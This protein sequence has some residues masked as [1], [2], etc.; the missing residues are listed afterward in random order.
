MDLRLCLG[1]LE[2]SGRWKN[3]QGSPMGHYR[4]STQGCLG[5]DS[6]NLGSGCQQVQIPEIG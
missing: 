2:M 4:E 6:N 5:A 3:D 1:V